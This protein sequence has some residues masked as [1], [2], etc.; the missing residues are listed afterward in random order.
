M[1]VVLFLVFCKLLD[2]KIY[3]SFFVVFFKIRVDGLWR[4]I[5]D[6]GRLRLWKIY[7]FNFLINIIIFNI[8]VLIIENF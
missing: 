4:M 6:Y 7:G 8:I 2:G 5:M 3:V 1:I